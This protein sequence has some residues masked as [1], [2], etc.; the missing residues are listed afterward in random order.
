MMEMELITICKITIFCG[1]FFIPFSILLIFVN[2][3]TIF[4][5]FNL[6]AYSIASIYCYK[7]I[8]KGKDKNDK[9]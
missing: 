1:L 3:A 5:Y 6:F 7:Q 2:E 4:S 8:K 9:L